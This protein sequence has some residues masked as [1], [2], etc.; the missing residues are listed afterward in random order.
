[1]TPPLLPSLRPRT[2]TEIVDAAITL[3]RGHYAHF[4]QVA[5]LGTIP[6][7]GLA[8]AQTLV[9]PGVTLPSSPGAPMT[10]MVGFVALA[11]VFSTLFG[12]ATQGALSVSGLAALQERELPSVV[13]AF[14]QA[15]RRLPALI[16]AMVLGAAG[17]G[18]AALPLAFGYAAAVGVITLQTGVAGR[19]GTAVVIALGLVFTVLVFGG[20]VLSYGY[21]ALVTS[22]VVLERLG[23]VAALRR[24]LALMRGSVLRTAVVWA[25]TLVLFLAVFALAFGLAAAAG[26]DQIAGAV[27]TALS[28]PAVPIFGMV[29][30]VQYADAR[31]RREGADLE[32]ALL[33]LPAA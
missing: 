32:A 2:A 8:L 6:S 9:A 1:M 12:F 31:T 3:V 23:P 11:L 29:A 30:L 18:L 10:A 24:A 13:S 20:M 33:G 14:G 19:A 27:V 15:F 21:F 17:I 5:A 25:I 28:I 22:L 7:L 26:N 16:G 4:V